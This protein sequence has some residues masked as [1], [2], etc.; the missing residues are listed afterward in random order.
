MHSFTFFFLH[1]QHVLSAA[2]LRGV[3]ILLLNYNILINIVI[4]IFCVDCK[5][6][7]S[8]RILCSAVFVAFSIATLLKIKVFW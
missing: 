7:Y 4:S 8:A 6:C 1:F 3:C 2:C 5:A